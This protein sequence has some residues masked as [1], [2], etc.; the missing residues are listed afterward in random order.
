MTDYSSEQLGEH[1][2]ELVYS[3]V[4]LV[5]DVQGGSSLCPGAQL[6][7]LPLHF[8]SMQALPHSTPA[9]GCDHI[10]D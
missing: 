10:V 9:T 8:V 1:L 6:S 2:Q 5:E 7:L 3:G 4:Q